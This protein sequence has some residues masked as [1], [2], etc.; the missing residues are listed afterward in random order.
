MA[1]TGAPRHW[2]FVCHGEPVRI[3][4]EGNFVTDQAALLVQIA[5]AGAGIIQV[6][7]YLVRPA[8]QAGRL[9]PVLADYASV[10][11]PLSVV[12]PQARHPALRV[13]LFVDFLLGLGDRL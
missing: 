10:G 11:P 6:P 3:F 13:R 2:S 8:L 7:R 12:Y 9:Q 4:P 1:S 5:E